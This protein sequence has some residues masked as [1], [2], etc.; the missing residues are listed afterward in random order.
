MFDLDTSAPN[1]IPVRYRQVALAKLDVALD[2]SSLI[3]HFVGKEAYM[4]TRFVVVDNGD[5]TA[6]VEVDRPPSAALFSTIADVRVVAGPEDCTYVAAPGVDVGVPAQLA[7]V[8]D[9]TPGVAC[10]V[11]EG[12]YS[13][14]SFVLNPRPMRLRVLDIVPPEPSKLM[15][16]AR[17]VLAVAEDL[18]PVLLAP[19]VVDSRDLLAN[20]GADT[21]AVLLPCSATGVDFGT[22]EVSFLDRRP[23]RGTWTLLGCERSRQI[24][25]W[26]YDD[27][28]PMIDTCP[29]GFLTDRPG[30]A[31]AMLTR[32]CLLEEGMETRDRTVIV[33]WGS[34]LEEVRAAIRAAFDAAGCSWT[35]V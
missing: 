8:A 20:A 6:L 4:R 35:P 7:E 16:Q 30:G 2:E 22:A 21:E 14:V 31:D 5:G 32:C 13:H 11:V 28:A 25:E 10:V 1:V 26:F 27:E 3:E 34:T 18:P 15:D 33:P 29:R 23:D 9:R 24:H 12:C 17:R 19:D